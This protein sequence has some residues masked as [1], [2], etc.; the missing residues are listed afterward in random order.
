MPNRMIRDGLLTSWRY[1]RLSSDG[2]LFFFHVLL[3]A[4]DLGCIELGPTYLRR[5][6]LF[7]QDS[8]ERIS[9]LINELSDVDLLRPYQVKMTCYGFIPNFGQRLQVKYAKY[10]LPSESLY[11]DDSDATQKFNQIKENARKS[12]VGQRMANRCPVDGQRTV[13]GKRE[14]VSGKE[15]K[16]TLS[17]SASPK[18][19][20]ASQS[21]EIL[22]YL[23]SLTGRKFRPVPETLKPIQARL[24]QGFSV[25]RLKEIALLK[26][27]QW[28]VDEKMVEYLRPKTLYAA[29]N[30][31]NYD[32]VLPNG[33]DD[34]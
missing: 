14:A 24:K 3:C 1:E 32:G 33:V 6:V 12:T 26:N 4:D 7:S 11:A 22:E 25:A 30:C 5:R 23:N 8:D 18:P 27:E 28:G 9:K 2:K 21:R 10:P 29:T 15:E 19:D 34:A 16:T 13:S 31:A 17:V 20:F